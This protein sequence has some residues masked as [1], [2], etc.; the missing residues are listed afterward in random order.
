MLKNKR[1]YIVAALIITAIAVVIGM[2]IYYAYT[3]N[4][5]CDI[6]GKKVTKKEFL[7]L[8]GEAKREILD[9]ANEAQQGGLDEQAAAAFWTTKI[10][11]KDA[12]EVAKERALQSAKDLKV[13]M[14]MAERNKIELTQ[15]EVKTFK[16]NIDEMIAKSGGEQSFLS[17]LMQYGINDINTFANVLLQYKVIEKFIQSELPKYS[18][19]EQDMRS[20]YDQNSDKFTPNKNEESVWA[21]HILIKT[22]DA[23][24]NLLPE[25]VIEEAR[26]KVEDILNRI[27]AG[28]DFASLATQFTE[29]PGSKNNGGQYL[30]SRGQM[31]EPFEQAAFS[32]QPGEVSGIVETEFGYHIIK[33]EEKISAAQPIS[34]DGAQKC[35]AYN[36]DENYM[37]NLTYKRNLEEWKKEYDVN[38][39]H[40]VYDLIKVQ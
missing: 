26:K 12:S 18:V 9:A 10:G 33:C 19:A 13:Q 29:D 38:I 8:L 28:E 23:N 24:G 32:L 17:G 16:E 20:Y 25:P 35:Y 30:F 3:S 1:T 22:V 37:K 14:I 7:L 2:N 34:F 4:Y 21:R 15:T 27:K 36:L 39:N 40:R 6:G 31:V 5:V 11:G